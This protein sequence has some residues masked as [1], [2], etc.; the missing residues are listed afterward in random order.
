MEEYRTILIKHEGGHIQIRVP[1]GEFD[2]WVYDKDGQ[3]IN[4]GYVP[5]C[6]TEAVF[7]INAHEDI[8]VEDRKEEI[9]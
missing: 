3:P 7:D 9:L 4:E 2:F 8:W 5:P 1:K 6:N